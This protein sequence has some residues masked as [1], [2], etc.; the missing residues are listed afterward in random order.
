VQAIGAATGYEPQ[1]KLK[2][3]Q[4]APAEW[5]KGAR[6]QVDE[7]ATTDGF[8]A[9][10]TLGSDFATFEAHGR[11]MLEI[12]IAE[13]A[14]L[15]Q[16]QGVTGQDAVVALAASATSEDHAH[17]I[18]EAMQ[19]LVRYHTTAELL[20]TVTMRGTVTARTRLGAVVVPALVNYFAWTQRV[21]EFARRSDLKASGQSV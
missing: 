2:A 5:L 16:L 19:M 7:M 9:R 15:E 8:L 20:D 17:F 11:G 6:F 3:S 21:A 13:V 1:P 14:A 18:V 4:L 12:R 10:C